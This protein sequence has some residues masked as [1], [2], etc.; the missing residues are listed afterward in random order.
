M[1]YSIYFFFSSRRR[2]TRFDCAW[3]SDVCSSDLGGDAELTLARGAA[4]PLTGRAR[5][6]DGDHTPA[7][8]RPDGVW[9]QRDG[10]PSPPRHHADRRDLGAGHRASPSRTSAALHP[11]K[12]SEVERLTRGRAAR[13]AAVT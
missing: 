12:P 11:P 6:L 10:A 2:H 3:S 5:W 1:T 9:W 7:R 4:E 13:G 8:R